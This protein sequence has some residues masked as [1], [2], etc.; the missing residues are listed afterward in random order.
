MQMLT[1]KAKSVLLATTFVCFALA[2][3]KAA[4]KDSAFE[5]KYKAAKTQSGVERVTVVEIEKGDVVQTNVLKISEPT[6]PK[7][8]VVEQE[9]PPTLASRTVARVIR[10]KV[11]RLRYCLLDNSVR[12]KSGKAVLTLTIKPSGR[13]ASV[14]VKAPGFEGSN[15]AACVRRSASLWRFP[16]FKKGEVTQSYP[17]IFKGR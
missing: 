8:S 3:C 2:A 7:G 9:L 14:N 13:V 11:S 15:L 16:K 17:V 6:P 4:D 5:K 12:G 1:R 10:S